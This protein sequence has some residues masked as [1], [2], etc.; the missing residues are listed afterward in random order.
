MGQTNR[1]H[2][3]EITDPIVIFLQLL[4]ELRN[5]LI[6]TAV[7]DISIS[8][9]SMVIVSAR[10]RRFIVAS[11]CSW[12]LSHTITTLTE[13]GFLIL[14]MIYDCGLETAGPCGMSNII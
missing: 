12:S 10:I 13:R 1:R 4:D 9:S 8:Y 2:I 5:A 11:S 14:A 6:S 3:L 7:I